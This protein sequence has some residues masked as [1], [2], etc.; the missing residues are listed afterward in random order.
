MVEGQRGSVMVV[1]FKYLHSPAHNSGSRDVID[2]QTRL[3]R[4]LTDTA[5]LDLVE[6]WT[7]C[8]IYM[9]RDPAAGLMD[10]GVTWGGVGVGLG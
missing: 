3:T 10:W 1:E 5:K 9:S 6:S 4:P 2:G 7:S 8:R